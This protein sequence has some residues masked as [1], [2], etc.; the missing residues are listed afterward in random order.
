[1]IRDQQANPQLSVIAQQALSVKEAGSQL[2]WYFLKYKVLISR[3]QPS[4]VPTT[5]DEDKLPTTEFS[6]K[7]FEIILFDT[8]G[9]SLKSIQD[10]F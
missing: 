3:W 7:Y 6:R 2:V 9:W 1:M 5:A 4:D 8:N 10:L